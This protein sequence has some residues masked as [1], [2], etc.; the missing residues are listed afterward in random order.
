MVQDRSGAADGTCSASGV[1]QVQPVVQLNSISARIGTTAATPADGQLIIGAGGSGG[2]ASAHADELLIDNNG[3]SGITIASGASDYGGINFS[4]SGNN[5]AGIVRYDHSDNSLKLYTQTT[6]RLTI[7]SSGA[8][9]QTASNNGGDVTSLQLRNHGA[10]T[11]TSTSLRFVNSTV[12]T[13]TAG[14]AEI[15]SIRNAN[16]GGSLVF[17]PAADTTATLTERMRI[18]SSG[19]VKIAEGGE[20]I[21]DK[22]EAGNGTIRFYKGGSASSYIQYDASENLVHYMPSSTGE[23]QFYTGG[24]KRLAISSTGLATFS[25]GINLGDTTLS[26]YAEGTWTPALSKGSASITSPGVATGRYIRVGNSLY[27]SFYFYK[28]SAATTTGADAWDISGLPFN[29]VT[30]QAY[31]SVSCGYVKIQSTSYQF[32]SP[33]RWQLSTSTATK[34]SLFGTER[35]TNN[36][37][38]NVE[39][40][41]FG[42]L[43]IA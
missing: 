34:L 12:A 40:S 9:A 27:V 36:T 8:V 35:A 30:G 42:V 37:G 21:I 32:T 29:C 10:D 15:T 43:E 13:A 4:D 24:S 33:Y 22:A 25:N 2:T 26:N 20:L 23:Q 19:A 18:D 28:G 7:D 3:N 6:E 16:D 17:K 41:G 31:Q 11:S 38:G 1:T 5:S 39:F 14:G